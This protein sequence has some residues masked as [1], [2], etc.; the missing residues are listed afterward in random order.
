M[1]NEEIDSYIDS[2]A[3]IGRIAPGYGIASGQVECVRHNVRELVRKVMQ[4]EREACAKAME[5]R[6]A[7]ERTLG[8]DPTNDTWLDRAHAFEDAA[9]AIRARGNDR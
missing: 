1:T 8:D 9:E 4:E 2:S 6:A 5:K 7:H 3:I